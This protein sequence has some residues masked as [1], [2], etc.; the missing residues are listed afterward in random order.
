METGSKLNLKII[1]IFISPENYCL[2]IR[3]Y[4]IELPI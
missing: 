3:L 4:N 1:I 2:E